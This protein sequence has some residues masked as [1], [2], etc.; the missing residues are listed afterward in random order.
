[1]RLVAGFSSRNPMNNMYYRQKPRVAGRLFDPGPPIRSGTFRLND[2][3]I[4]HYLI[5]GPRAALVR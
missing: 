1:V 5:V 3:C 2:D 4:P